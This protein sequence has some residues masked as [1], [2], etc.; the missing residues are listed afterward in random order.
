MKTGSWQRENE[1]QQRER[2]VDLNPGFKAKYDQ[3]ER[4][5]DLN[6]GFKAKY[7]QRKSPLA[8]YR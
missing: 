8:G 5:V 4:V 2:G 7:D 1:K 6:P 3:R